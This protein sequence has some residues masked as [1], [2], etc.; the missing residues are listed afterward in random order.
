MGEGHSPVGAASSVRTPDDVAP[1]R[2]LILWR[3]R[4]YNDASPTDF[5]A[6]ATFAR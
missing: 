1:E 5:G 2:S 4:F 3:C 6:F